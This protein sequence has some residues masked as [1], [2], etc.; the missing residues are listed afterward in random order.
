MLSKEPPDVSEAAAGGQLF[1]VNILNGKIRGL[2]PPSPSFHCLRYSSTLGYPI[3]PPGLCT[4]HT[5][6]H[7]MPPPSIIFRIFNTRKQF[8]KAQLKIP[9]HDEQRTEK[10]SLSIKRKHLFGGKKNPET[11]YTTDTIPYT[12]PVLREVAPQWR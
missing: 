5:S 9:T 10:S 4:T 6:V 12:V 7:K 3:N 8:N 2:F 1:R 11:A